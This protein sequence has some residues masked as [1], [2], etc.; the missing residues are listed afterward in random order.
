MTE[1]LLAKG[2]SSS[3]GYQVDV[4][5]P[6]ASSQLLE[7]KCQVTLAVWGIPLDASLVINTSRRGLEQTSLADCCEAE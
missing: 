5:N 2:P 6:G 7:T 1:A 4:E 3:R